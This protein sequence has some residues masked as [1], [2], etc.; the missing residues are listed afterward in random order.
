LTEVDGVLKVAPTDELAV[1]ATGSVVT[2]NAA[3]TPH[4]E[5]IADLV[6]LVAGSAATTGLTASAGVLTVASRIAHIVADQKSSLFVTYA[7]FDAGTDAAVDTKL[8]DALEAKGQ[9]IAAF[10]IVTELF[11]GTADT[12]VILSSAATGATAIA[13][14]IVM[15][16]GS[17]QLVGSVVGA[18]PVAGAN[19]IVASGGDVYAYVAVDAT[20][21][22]G[23]IGFILLWMKTA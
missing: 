16:N 2:V 4:K 6:G 22:T 8:T 10:G 15:D 12:T 1:L 20:R 17:S 21:S 3:G 7:E 18:W 9:L 11:N 5:A 14:N 23:K 13:S 19:S